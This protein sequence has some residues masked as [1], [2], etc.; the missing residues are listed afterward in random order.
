MWRDAYKARLKAEGSNIVEAVKQTTKNGNIQQ[1]LYSPT[2]SD[3]TVNDN[4]GLYPCIVSDMKTFQ[5]RRFLFLPDTEI[6]LGDYIYHEGYTYLATDKTTSDTYPQLIGDVCNA[7]FPISTEITKVLID[8]DDRGRPIYNEQI[9]LNNVPC[10]VNS[11]YFQA[12]ETRNLLVPEGKVVVGV[13]YRADHTVKLNDEFDIH[14][15]KYKVKDIDLTSLFNGKGVM[16]IIA[17][18]VV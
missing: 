16:N 3:V 4:E 12:N 14:G 6:N 1:I 11:Y 7:E 15:V 13:Q 5:K 10:T 2:R 17:E 8:K 18:K 9:N